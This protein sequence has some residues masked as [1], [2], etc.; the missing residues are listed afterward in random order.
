MGLRIRHA[1]HCPSC[2]V[3]WIGFRGFCRVQPFS[4]VMAMLAWIRCARVPDSGRPRT[5]TRVGFALHCLLPPRLSA[6]LNNIHG[7]TIKWAGSCKEPEPGRQSGRQTRRQPG[8]RAPRQMACQ[9]RD[10]ASQPSSCNMQCYN[11]I[12][13]MILFYTIHYTL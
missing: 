7:Q 4:C 1:Y 10:S 6:S 5:K 9:P 3:V 2:L 8:S 13:Y 11:M 12:Y